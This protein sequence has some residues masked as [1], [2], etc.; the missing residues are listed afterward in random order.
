MSDRDLQDFMAG[1]ATAIPVAIVAWLVI[2]WANDLL[3]EWIRLL[4]F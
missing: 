3:S 4:H 1:G 2:L